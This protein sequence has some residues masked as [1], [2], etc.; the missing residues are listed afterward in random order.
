MRTVNYT[1]RPIST[2][3]WLPD[4]CLSFDQPFH[5]KTASPKPG[6]PSLHTYTKGDR[7]K[8]PELYH[9]VLSTFHCCGFIAWIENSVVGYN[10]FFPCQF[11]RD[12]GF[13]GCGQ[14]Q[15][16]T[17]R[18]LVHNCISVI[19]NSQF[20]RQGIGTNLIQH[21]L[22]WAKQNDWERFQVH[23]VLPDTPAAF[24]NDQKSCLTFWT[25]FGFEIIHREK[26][27]RETKKIYGVNE[28]YSVALNLDK[29]QL[30]N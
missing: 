23:F 22:G 16:D 3:E 29:W 28:T 30:T 14:E 6:C 17:S 5:Y 12:I 8:L 15:R 21:S 1:I 25:R 24:Q 27:C 10:N 11:A 9:K 7:K 4:R 2:T 20:R 26:A 19:Q 18:T 13:Y